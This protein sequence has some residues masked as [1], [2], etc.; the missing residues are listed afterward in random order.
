[1]CRLSGPDSCIPES[2][3]RGLISIR[4]AGWVSRKFM[5]GTRLWPPARKRASSPYSAF[6]AKACSSDRA[7]MYLKGAG[8]MLLERPSEGEARLGSKYGKDR[9]GES[10]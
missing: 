2:C 1:M 8:F 3:V 6:S 4:T 9:Q 7:A 5:V 10:K